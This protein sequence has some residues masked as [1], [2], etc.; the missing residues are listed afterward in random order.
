[1]RRRPAGDVLNLDVAIVGGGLAGNLLARQLRRR[2]PELSVALF[3]RDTHRDYKVGE[4][5]VEIASNYLLRRQGLSTYLY[6]SQLP[7][8][9][10]RF[11]YDT[12]E[13]SCPLERMSEIGTVSLPF[14]PSFQLDRARLEEDLLGMNQRAGVQVWLPARVEDIEL[15]EDGAPHHLR[16][17]D[18]HRSHRVSARW[19]VDGAGRV[20]LLA[21]RLGLRVP[22]PEHRLG[23]AWARYENLLDVDALGSEAFRA[24]VNYTPRRL[25][26][27][28]LAYPGYWIWL[29]PLRGGLTSVGVTGEQVARSRELRTP[30]GFQAFLE[31][32]GALAELLAGAK[33]VDFG[34]YARIAYATQRFFDARS[35]WA[36]IGE[37]ATSADPL[38]SPGSDFI[39]LEN[40]FATDLIARDLGEG[41][42]AELDERCDLYDGFMKFRHEA[43]I[44][45]YRGLYSTLGSYDLARAKW[46]FDIGSYYNLWASYYLRELHL[47]PDHLRHQLRLAPLVLRAMEGFAGLFRRAEA[48]LRE[49][50]RYFEGNSDRFYHG[51]THIPF[52]TRIGE[53]RSEEEVVSEQGR[54]FNLVRAQALALMGRA[55]SVEAVEPLPLPSFFTG[56]AFETA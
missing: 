49:Q 24:R 12:A 20:G 3:E 45:L 55:E 17:D 35:R 53:E 25:A 44:R 15:G 48:T 8:N 56:R 36:L 18:G 38:Y 4:S 33:Q 29:I 54:L 10:L 46:D 47:E 7:K 40:D 42:R 13:R 51:L 5:T 39:A 1:M 22:E 9:G 26:T 21:Q 37:A 50:G 41:T 23:S 43:T 27:I 30:Q 2:L 31:S 28:H 14:H 11:F 6:E 16:V 34:S 19:L 52:E 32:H